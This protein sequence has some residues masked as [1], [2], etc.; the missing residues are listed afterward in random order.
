M[1]YHWWCQKKCSKHCVLPAMM[2]TNSSKI[3]AFNLWWYQKIVQIIVFYRWWCP[4]I[5]QII[6]FDEGW[7]PKRARITAF[8]HWWYQ[9]I[10]QINVF[11]KWC[12]R[13]A[14]EMSPCGWLWIQGV[15]EQPV[16]GT[17]KIPVQIQSV[18]DTK[19][20]RSDTARKVS[21]SCIGCSRSNLAKVDNIRP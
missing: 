6:V 19:N 10:A 13:V 14:T 16:L 9:K 2:P 18:P 3:T 7:C 5:I 1:F 11:Y 12:P 8:Y 20:A 15:L 21:S 17:G 4:Q